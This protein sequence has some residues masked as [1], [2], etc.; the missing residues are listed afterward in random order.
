MSANHNCNDK[1]SC[2]GVVLIVLVVLW[3]TGNCNG[4]KAPPTAPAATAKE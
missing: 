2:L 3:L 4:P 1:P